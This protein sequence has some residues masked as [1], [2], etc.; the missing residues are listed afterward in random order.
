MFAREREWKYDDC[1]CGCGLVER[2]MHVLFECNLYG[3]ME[4]G[5]RRS[6]G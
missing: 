2:D 6:E 3:E 4:R 1:R 5:C